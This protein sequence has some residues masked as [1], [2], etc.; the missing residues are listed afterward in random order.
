MKKHS[1]KPEITFLGVGFSR[2]GTTW[3]HE[4]LRRHPESYVPGLRKEL[5]FFNEDNF[6]KGWA[7]YRKFFAPEDVISNCKAVGE[8]S[9][10]YIIRKNALEKIREAYPDIQIICNLRHPADFL[11]SHYRFDLRRGIFQGRFDDFLEEKKRNIEISRYLPY[12]KNLYR[13]FPRKNIC[14]LINEKDVRQ[15]EPSVD[16]LSEFLGLKKELFPEAEGLKN[17]NASYRPR[18]PFGQQDSPAGGAPASET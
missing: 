13:M 4:V 7:W 14:V 11:Y 6:K 5:S 16:I 8:I 3:L 18:F 9:T 12:L 17:V 15:H 2:S 1:Q 10:G